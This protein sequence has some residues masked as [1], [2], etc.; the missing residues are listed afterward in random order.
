MLKNKL[1]TERSVLWPTCNPRVQ[2]HLNE[3]KQV[4][5]ETQENKGT[6][7][8]GL[9]DSLFP[10]QTHSFGTFWKA[11]DWLIFI[12]TI[13]FMYLLCGHLLYF[14]A[15]CYIIP[16]LV[17]CIKKNLATLISPTKD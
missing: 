7:A 10:N 14:V 1:K 6:L 11:F 13:W 4:C 12:L 2:P 16:I 3:A 8:P 5:T 17:N 9:P 15:L